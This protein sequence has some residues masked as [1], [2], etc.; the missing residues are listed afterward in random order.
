MGGDTTTSVTDAVCRYPP[1]ADGIHASQPVTLPDRQLV[2]PVLTG[3][4]LADRLAEH[5][6]S[7]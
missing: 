7:F 1:S 4:V 6:A 2:N 3:L 5:R